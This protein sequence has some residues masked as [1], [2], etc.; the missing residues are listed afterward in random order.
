MLK[1]SHRDE[2][3]LKKRFVKSEIE[4]MCANPLYN[5]HPFEELLKKE[6]ADEE[7]KKKVKEQKLIDKR[8]N[9]LLRM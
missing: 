7:K 9:A 4:M 3:N 8:Y 2:Y 1:K 6:E 5:S